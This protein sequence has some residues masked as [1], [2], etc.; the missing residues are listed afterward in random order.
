MIKIP[1]TKPYFGEEEKRALI[2]TLESGW[3]VQGPKVAEFE[4]LFAEFTGAKYA[5]ATTSCTTALHLSLIAMGIGPGDEV[6]LPSLT[7]VATANVI[8]YTGATPVFCDIDLD[9]FNI[10]VD[11]I[12][13]KISRKTKAIIPVHLFGL[14]AEMDTIMD[15]ANH[16]NLKVIED[17]ACG[18]GTYYNGRHVGN[19][20]NIG[21][22]SF[23]PRKVITTGEGGMIITND[24]ELM[25]TFRSL[26]DHGAIKSD[27]ER[28]IDLG[29][30][31]LPEFNQLGYNYRLTDLQ[32]ALGIAQMKR[33]KEIIHIRKSRAERYHQILKGE[34]WI[35]IPEVTERNTHS[36][37][38]YVCLIKPKGRLLNIE[39]PSFEEVSIL[40]EKRNKLMG[41]LESRG[42]AVRQGTHAVHNLGYYKKKYQIRPEDY[43][44]SLIA[45]K[46]SITLPLYCQMTDKEQNH[47]VEELKKCAELLEF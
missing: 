16:Y 43:M 30:S 44:N 34:K 47:V 31:L 35:K 40:H 32:G 22:F 21:C 23:H 5:I 15:L 19:I 9:S 46:L 45:E 24:P 27:L 18:L 11:E 42:I 12:Q 26:R 33:L 38:S 10:R 28:H 13:K 36:Y 7:F 20:G 8:E 1:I 17:S 6:L 2:E 4:R 39:P 41:Y 25:V 37:Q 3:I 14:S 29:G